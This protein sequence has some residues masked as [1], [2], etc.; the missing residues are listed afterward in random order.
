VLLCTNLL[1]HEPNISQ[2]GLDET[3]QG[4][5]HAVINHGHTQAGLYSI[6]PRRQLHRV[7]RMN[8]GARFDNNLQCFWT[9]I[10]M[11]ISGGHIPGNDQ[12][13]VYCVAEQIHHTL[14]PFDTAQVFNVV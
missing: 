6:L 9:Y 4:G 14:L 3:A 2:V 8:G 12:D 5:L 10:C 11:Y 7:C 13:L 1:C